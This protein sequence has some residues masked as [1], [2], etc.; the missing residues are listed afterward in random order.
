MKAT[1][2][3]EIL[4][5]AD[6]SLFPGVAVSADMV[7]TTH[8]LTLVI[9]MIWQKPLWLALIFYFIIGGVEIFYCSSVLLKVPKGGWVPIVFVVVFFTVMSTWHYGQSQKYQYEM[10]NRVPMD[11][12]LELGSDLGMLRVPGIGLVY[13]ELGQG[14]PTIFHHLLTRFPAMHSV[15]AF[16]CVKYL[17]VSHVPDGERFLVRRVGP[18][19]FRLYRCAVRFGYKEL[20]RDGEDN[21]SFENL[22]VQS[23]V[24]FIKEEHSKVQELILQDANNHEDENSIGVQ[25]DERGPCFPSTEA[26]T[27]LEQELAILD[28]AMQSGIVHLLG[29][30]EIRTRKD[31]SWLKKL[32]ID[33][34][35][36]TLK[37]NCRSSRVSLSVPHARLLQVGM[38]HDI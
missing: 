30:T 38:I 15:L 21:E 28:N 13:T 11:L 19:K 37:V 2:A 33:Y 4:N 3:I 25:I 31:S 36:H 22:L 34:G 16:V 23:L 9:I 32:V 1:V 24:N 35:F 6:Y 10:Q 5:N 29:H 7:I 20:I 8:L 27:E 17:P 18:R 12:V 14:V 26:S